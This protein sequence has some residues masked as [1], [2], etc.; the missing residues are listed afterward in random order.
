[1]E[2]KK[3]HYLG[4]KSFLL[5]KKLS[6]RKPKKVP[7]IFAS[8]VLCYSAGSMALI[9]RIYRHSFKRGELSEHTTKI[10]YKDVKDKYP[11]TPVSFY[12]GKNRL[13]GY[14]YGEENDK[15]LIVFSHGIGSG[16]ENYIMNILWFADHG[17]R[18]FAFDN[19][20]SCESEGK[21]T[22]GL[23]QSALDL[24]AALTY[25][26]KDEELSKMKKV[27]CGHSWGGYAV[28]A[29]LNFHHDITASVS[30]SGYCKPLDMIIEEGRGILGKFAYAQYPNIWLNNK[31]I[32]GKHS[33]LSAIDGI[34]HVRI[35]VLII[36]GDGDKKI[37]YRGASIIS[38]KSAIKNP[39]VQYLTISD[40]GRNGHNSI[41]YS[42]EAAEY[43]E[44]F[45][46]EKK[47][48]EK[49]YDGKLPNDVEAD[50][51][52]K[53]DKRIANGQNTELYEKINRFYEAALNGGK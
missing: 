16:H 40:K 17:W 13:Q 12:S 53:A 8:V 24:D 35:P 14:I 6:K 10:R 32:F 34:N 50:F 36:H 45:E 22:R 25:I 29:V 44:K 51:Y 42:A 15:G 1:M 19:T 41:F 11:R 37:N 31:M 20:G 26:E 2:R 21:G 49:E 7:A 38:K 52:A 27:L 33:G 28:T 48:L 3:I 9:K 18:I 47:K 39:N 43:L 5:L 4:R 30:I 46:R 23:S